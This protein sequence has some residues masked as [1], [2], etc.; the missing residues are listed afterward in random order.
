[1]TE[2]PSEQINIEYARKVI[3]TEGRAVSGLLDKIAGEFSDAVE[4]IL[5]TEGRVV[6]TGMGKTGIV[7]E[8]LSATLS[9]TGTRSIFIHSAEAAH[10]DLGRI[11]EEDIVILM[12]KS[13]DTGEVLKLFDP[14]KRIGAKTIAITCE[15]GSPLA[16]Y[17]DIV[18]D[19][20]EIEEACPLGLA[21]SASTTAMMALG[22]ALALTVL[23]RRGFTPEEFARY[24]PAGAIG[25]Q[26]MKISEIMR[27]GD[28]LPIVAGRTPV[29]DALLAITNVR[30]GAA[31]IADENGLLEGI[32]T[33]GD[34]R[35]HLK[36]RPDLLEVPVSEVM[37]A[38]PLT[39]GPDALC[40]EAAKV[41]K[42]KKID[43]LPVVNENGLIVG[44]VDIQDLLAIGLI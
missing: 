30:G 7:G 39:I 14:I 23:S 31:V 2:K 21:P 20:G 18:L 26:L 13:G 16:E 37:T 19:L 40:T 12:S 15:Q 42:E 36:K 29:K 43:E 5:A 33:D 10:G 34:L 4:M 24:H 41:M 9:S 28:R 6:V 22:D 25:R 38:N 8:K 35:R 11:A 27:K 32:F 44:L 3:E 17:S 1:V